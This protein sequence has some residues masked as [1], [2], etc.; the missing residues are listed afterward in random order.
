MIRIYTDNSLLTPDNRGIAHPL[1]FD[2][3]YFEKTHK[4]VL[5]L[6]SLVDTP[7]SA[8]V[9]LFP[10]NYH[11]INKRGCKKHYRDLYNT[12]LKFEKRIMVY[13]GGDYGKTFK[14]DN[15]IVWRNAGF[16]SH[17][18]KQ[19][20]IIPAFIDDPIGRDEVSG[21]VI[22]YTSLPQISFTGFASKNYLERS[23]VIMSVLK[24]N[25]LRAFLKDETDF[26]N[27]F[28]AA[29]QRYKYLKKLEKSDRVETSFIYR[30]KYRAGA[31]SKAER[32]KTSKE[33]FENLNGAPYT[34]CLR[35]AGNFSVRFYEA[36]ACGR[37]PVLIDTDCHLP[38]EGIINWEQHI[39][40]LNVEDNIEE[41][42]LA[43]HKKY[44]QVSFATLQKS[45]RKLYVDYL[46]RD[47]FFCNLYHSLKRII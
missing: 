39:C 27:V 43:F 38:L 35:G 20:V 24:R 23:R 33:F 44:D 8:D 18:D 1:I 17:N 5:A 47:R 25:L 10:I 29:L 11:F 30:S 13:S 34:F 32:Q 40:K 7:E 46:V 15:V 22:N 36:L 41:A 42:L 12:A 31:R 2:L 16:K 3:Y 4:D 14:D 6:Y 9:F 28:Y 26:Q 19:T 45:N 37:I 21:E